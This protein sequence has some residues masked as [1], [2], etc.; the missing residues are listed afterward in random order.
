MFFEIR[1]FPIFRKVDFQESRIVR[2]MNDLWNVIYAIWCE[3]QIR[4][5]NLFKTK[6]QFVFYFK[7]KINNEM[8]VT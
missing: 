4:F 1:K 5:F 2:M 8:T 7:E 3:T 6:S